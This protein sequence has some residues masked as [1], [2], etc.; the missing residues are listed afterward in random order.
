MDRLGCCIVPLLSSDCVREL[1]SLHAVGFSAQGREGLVANHNSTPADHALALS[2]QIE[3]IV[4]C[5]LHD[6]FQDFRFFIGHFMVKKAGTD[7]EFP[8]HQDW[9][10]VHEAKYGSYQI[11]IPLELTEPYNGGMFFVPGSHSIFN[12]YRSGSFNISRIPT[13]LVI[14]PHIEK[15]IVPAG[16]AFVYS[17]ALFHGSYP[18]RSGRDRIN[19]IVN[20]VSK[21][22]STYYFHHIP[23]QRKA[24]CYAITCEDLVRNLPALE[25]GLLPFKMPVNHEEDVVGHLDNRGLDSKA[26]AEAVAASKELNPRSSL[27][28]PILRHL[29]LEK[30][31]VENGYAVVPLL[32]SNAVE[33]LLKLFSNHHAEGQWT[34]NTIHTSLM[35]CDGAMRRRIH[36]AIYDQLE[37]SLSDVFMNHK[38]PLCQFFV[39]FPGAETEIGLHTD[40]SLLLNPALEPHY[41]IWIPLQDVSSEN[42]TLSVIPGSH[43]WFS[44]V[45][46]ASVPWAFENRAKKL[47][48]LAETLDLGAGQMVIFDNRLL[49]GSVA[50]ISDTFRVCI[51][52]RITHRRSS[53]HSFFKSDD[54]GE[55]VGV[56]AE[57]D[58]IYLNDLW[59]GDRREH[60]DE[61]FLGNV[62]QPDPAELDDAIMSIY[63]SSK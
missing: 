58:D 21:D 60:S 45:A 42:G 56:Y 47:G 49:H 23:E 9:N 55:A 16:H 7:D 53:F 38:V 44:G 28:L 31:L 54:G 13:D 32:D 5:G 57:P 50:N 12:N 10:I 35:E 40:S 48:Q 19:V 63:C 20:I 33:E 29:R 39:K 51:A 2:R 52:G 36:Q 6:M 26:L 15:A 59:N 34:E 11:W 14:A 62:I 41:G 1:A 8:L 37:S 17:N 43:K 30:Q 18:N 46:S 24:E 4:T 22:A 27:M 61:V 25:Q 3:A